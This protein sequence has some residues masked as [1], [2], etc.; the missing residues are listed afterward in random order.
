M[1]EQKRFSKIIDTVSFV[2][3]VG[4]TYVFVVYFRS[5]N[6]SQLAFRYII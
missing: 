4:V 5:S 2:L 3:N 1:K 6:T